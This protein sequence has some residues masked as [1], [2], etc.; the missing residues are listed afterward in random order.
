MNTKQCAYQLSRS[1]KVCERDPFLDEPRRI[2]SKIWRLLRCARAVRRMLRNITWCRLIDETCFVV[3]CTHVNFSFTILPFLLSLQRWL[4][5]GAAL[6]SFL[7]T[8]ASNVPPNRRLGGASGRRA[9]DQRVTCVILCGSKRNPARSIAPRG[10]RDARIFGKRRR[11]RC[12]PFPNATEALEPRRRNS[13]L[14]EK[15]SMD[16]EVFFFY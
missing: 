13:H 5:R 15:E 10:T 8:T 16:R 7:P 3:R 2:M 9:Q 6:A 11:G 12:N 1:L 4:I 14:Y